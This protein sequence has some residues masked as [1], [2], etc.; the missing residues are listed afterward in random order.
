MDSVAGDHATF[1]NNVFF[2]G[3]GSG[4]CPGEF[5]TDVLQYHAQVLVRRH[6]PPGDYRK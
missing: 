4:F 2:R 5:H 3:A 1:K 6:P